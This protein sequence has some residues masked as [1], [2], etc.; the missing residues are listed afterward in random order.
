MS[1]SYDPGFL[2]LATREDQFQPLRR[3]DAGTLAL[4]FAGPLA[5]AALIGLAL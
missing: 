4:I 3:G 1:C 2:I 5:I